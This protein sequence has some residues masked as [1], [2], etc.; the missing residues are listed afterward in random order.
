MAKYG[1]L[2]LSDMGRAGFQL[3]LGEKIQIGFSPSSWT[4][5]FLPMDLGMGI[6]M[7]VPTWD[8]FANR[9]HL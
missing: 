2:I 6:P 4:P 1:S 7:L 3:E 9:M 5:W 8:Q